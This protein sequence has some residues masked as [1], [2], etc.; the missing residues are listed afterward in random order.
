MLRQHATVSRAF[1]F[2]QKHKKK[3]TQHC[4]VLRIAPVKAMVMAMKAILLFQIPSE[5]DYGPEG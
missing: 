3:P 5:E 1:V 2:W 4:A